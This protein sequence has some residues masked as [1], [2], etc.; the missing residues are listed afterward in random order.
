M[1]RGTEV[2]VVIGEG[3]VVLKP[4][5][6]STV[7]TANIL[8]ID[9]DAEGKAKVVYLDRFVHDRGLTFRGWHASGAISTILTK[10]S[11]N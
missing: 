1:V 10:D 2:D 8:G 4:V 5:N 7:V 3:V 11:G 6:A 9:E